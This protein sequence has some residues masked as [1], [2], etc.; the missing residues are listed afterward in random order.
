M[1]YELMMNGNIKIGQK[2]PDFI[3][4]TT[5]G[6]INMQDYKGKW[7]IIFSLPETFEPICSTELLAFERIYDKIKKLNCELIGINTDS[8]NAHLVWIYDIFKKTGI[9]IEFPIISD[10]NGKIARE[11]GMITTEKN[12]F[13]ILRNVIIIDDKG[14]IRTILE[15]PLNVERSI[16]EI[17]RIF[18]AMK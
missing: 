6:E 5:I 4:N 12:D 9:K 1:D 17:L 14:E 8:N 2:A 11:Y 15:Y 7:I 13:K 16:P 18:L 10:I 3:A